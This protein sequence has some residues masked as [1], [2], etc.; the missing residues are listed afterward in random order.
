MKGHEKQHLCYETISVTASAGGCIFSKMV[1]DMQWRKWVCGNEVRKG[2]KLHETCVRGANVARRAYA[3]FGFAN[4][5][6]KQNVRSTAGSTKQPYVRQS[7]C[8][9]NT[10]TKN[11]TSRKATRSRD[12]FRLFCLSFSCSFVSL[13]FICHLVCTH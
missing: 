1:G 8:C 5:L 7:V 3:E 9:V 6:R 11:S 4:L 12:A 2:L 10:L 13:V